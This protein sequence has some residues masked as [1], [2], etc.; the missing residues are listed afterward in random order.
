MLFSCRK[1][2]EYNQQ[3]ELGSLQQGL[4]TSMAIGY[5][6][7]IAMSAFKG[8]EL[9]PNVTVITKNSD[10]FTSSWNLYIKID[11]DHPLP[12]NNNIGDIIVSGLGDNNGGVI[13]I[14]FGDLNLLGGTIKLYGLY[15]V[16]VQSD[17]LDNTKITTVFFKEDFV[18]DK[19]QSEALLDFNLTKLQFDSKMAGLS[20]ESS[21]DPYIAVKQNFWIINIDQNNTYANPYD[22]NLTLNGGG[23]ILEVEGASGGIIYH[24][25][26]N[27]KVNY[28]V[29][30][31]NPTSG[32]AFS[33]NLKAGG[34][35][36]VDLGNSLLSFHSN[37]DGMAHVDL[38]TGKYLGYNGKNISLDV[39]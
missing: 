33:Q 31:K 38:S 2:I 30:P 27:T 15:L 5:C 22:D 6:A 8:K 18:F 20:K 35:V 29:C 23:Q 10:E 34:N 36:S 7:S 39:Q 37:C 9:P 3:P 19:S 11:N 28:S 21:S 12:F 26:I 16:P 14:V 13:S 1:Y 32:Y 4:K 25:I 17:I 24:A